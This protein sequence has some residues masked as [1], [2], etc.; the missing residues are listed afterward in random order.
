MTVDR[1][2]LALLEAKPGKGEAL[3]AFLEQGRALAAEETG[4]VT[5]YAFRI[6]E[7]TYGI[8]DTFENEEGRQ[9]HLTG[10]IPQ[11][12]GEVGPELLA[13]DPDIRPVDVIAVK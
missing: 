12:L 5:W 6:S 4:T 10:A 11:A 3:A 9:A 1:G 8:F 13:T 2:L 7:T